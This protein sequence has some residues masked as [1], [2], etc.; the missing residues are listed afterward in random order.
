MLNKLSD[1][2][3]WIGGVLL[4]LALLFIGWQQESLPMTTGAGIVLGLILG[5]S[6][7]W[8]YIDRRITTPEESKLEAARRQRREKKR[9][10]GR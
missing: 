7:A 1:K 10:N 3:L 2:A 9:K 5:L 6:I 4:M 8:Q